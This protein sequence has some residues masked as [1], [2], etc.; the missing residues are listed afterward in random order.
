[1][2]LS[3]GGIS[4]DVILVSSFH[5]CDS[6][7]WQSHSI[8]CL[9]FSLI[10]WVSHA[11]LFDYRWFHYSWQFSVPI[12]CLMPFPWLR[13]HGFIHARIT[14]RF[15]ALSFFTEPH[16][17]AMWSFAQP[18][19]LPLSLVACLRLPCIHTSLAQWQVPRPFNYTD[20]ACGV[21]IASL[22]QA[23]WILMS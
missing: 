13:V 20:L 23:L 22:G 2:S 19:D 11:V 15:H 7:T 3:L 14:Y 16:R 18:I 17:L 10:A 1:M 5:S 8:L 6:T 9:P 12:S 4:V 21:V